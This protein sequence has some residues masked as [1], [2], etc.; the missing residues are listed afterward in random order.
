MHNRRLTHGLM[1]LFE[2]PPERLVEGLID[3]P[4]LHEPISQEPHVPTLLS[5]RWV[6][7]GQSHQIRLLV[8]IERASRFPASPREQP[9]TPPTGTRVLVLLIEHVLHVG[10]CRHLPKPATPS[11]NTDQRVLTLA[12]R[13]NH[14]FVPRRTFEARALPLFDPSVYKWPLQRRSSTSRRTA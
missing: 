11:R 9:P 14:S 6:A 1:S 3:H 12:A 4:N 8:C 13:R 5:L 2:R 7:T 10:S